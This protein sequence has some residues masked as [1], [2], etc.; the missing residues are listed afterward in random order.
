MSDEIT[1]ETENITANVTVESEKNA[2]ETE[3]SEKE[4]IDSDES[5]ND[6]TSNQNPATESSNDLFDALKEPEK[7]ES[8]NENEDAVDGE[9][10]S[11]EPMEVDEPPASDSEDT[12]EP[13]K[14]YEPENETEQPEYSQEEN[15]QPDDATQDET[16][17]DNDQQEK[18]A[19]DERDS[20]EQAQCTDAVTEMEVD[21]QSSQDE[22]DPKPSQGKDEVDKIDKIDKS[23][24]SFMDQN[25]EHFN[26]STVSELPKDKTIADDPF[27]S[28]LNNDIADTLSIQNES[29]APIDSVV[30]D[31]EQQDD[32]DDQDDEDDSTSHHDEAS[33]GMLKSVQKN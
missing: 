30:D 27:D 19:N 25:M 15:A 11:Q 2:T 6:E 7:G 13:D 16:S 12:P 5:N 3:K 18:P 17:Q 24:D 31:N 33:E 32:Q 26:C 22:T 1:T 4:V 23:N 29:T 9:I 28:L 14:S 21:L 10:A 8:K 20:V